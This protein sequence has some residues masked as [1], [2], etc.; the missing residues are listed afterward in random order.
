MSADELNTLFEQY[1]CEHSK[2]VFKF[3]VSKL[4]ANPSCAEDCVQESYKVLYEKM[5]DGKNIENVRAFL[6]QTASNFV[7]KNLTEMNRE[8]KHAE[9]SASANSIPYNDTY[10]SNIPEILILHLKDEV[11]DTLTE[12]DRILIEKI[13]CSSDGKRISE[14][15]LAEEYGCSP[16]AMRQRISVLHKKVKRI[17]YEK[18]LDLDY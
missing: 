10:F 17:V 11:L 9:Y 7:K 8:M 13:S 16:G 6:M 4:N 14:K 1:F 12:K 2:Q 5:K 3:C 15:E 18:T